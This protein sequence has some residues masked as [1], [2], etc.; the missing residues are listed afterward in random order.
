[1]QREIVESVPWLKPGGWLLLEIADD[2]TSKVRRMC[3][4]AGLTDEGVA[5]DEDGLSVIVEARKPIG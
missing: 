2:L 1:M 4:R 5:T 3:R